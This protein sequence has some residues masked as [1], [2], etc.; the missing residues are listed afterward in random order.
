[1]AHQSN[2]SLIASPMWVC[3]GER[4]IGKWRGGSGCTKVCSLTKA[5]ANDSSTEAQ[6]E[7]GIQSC[8]P[9]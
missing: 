8:V 9:A 6:G 1:M 2:V 3:E 7:P 5:Q 4:M